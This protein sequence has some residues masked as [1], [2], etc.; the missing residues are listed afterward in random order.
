M[1]WII[2]G[3]ATV[4]ALFVAL[5]REMLYATDSESRG[6]CVILVPLIILVGYQVLSAIRLYVSRL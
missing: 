2:F 1:V 3:V 5:I 6:S 4:I